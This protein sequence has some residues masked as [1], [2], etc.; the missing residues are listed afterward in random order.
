MGGSNAPGT[1]IA[2]D[3]LVWPQREKMHLILERL[4]APRKGVALLEARG[5]GRG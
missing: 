2:Q 5:R 4:E 1:S 3:S